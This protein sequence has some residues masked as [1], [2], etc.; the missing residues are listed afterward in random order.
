MPFR[1]THAARPKQEAELKTYITLS[2]TDPVMTPLRYG[3][4]FSALTAK[5]AKSDDTCTLLVSEDWPFCFFATNVAALIT[6]ADSFDK[7]IEG[8]RS[9]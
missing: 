5:S 1:L 7:W 3:P 2:L 4:P 6:K 8:R 9:P